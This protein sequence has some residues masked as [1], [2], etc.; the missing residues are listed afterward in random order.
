MI[1]TL[2]LAQERTDNTLSDELRLSHTVVCGRFSK[3]NIHYKTIENNVLYLSANTRSRLIFPSSSASLLSAS[4][5]IALL[6]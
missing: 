3:N 6:L 5:I 4:L 1:E 2:G